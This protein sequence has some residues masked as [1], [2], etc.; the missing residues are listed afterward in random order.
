MG[1]GN[2]NRCSHSEE[3]GKGDTQKLL[4]PKQDKDSTNIWKLWAKL[5]NIDEYILNK[6]LTNQ[7]Q[8]SGKRVTYND[9]IGFSSYTRL[10]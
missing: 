6:L 5:M 3:E 1:Q 8:Q 10:I 7:I 4:I 9:Q 2:H